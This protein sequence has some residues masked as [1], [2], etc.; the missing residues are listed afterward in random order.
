MRME[1]TFGTLSMEFLGNFSDYILNVCTIK[2]FLK[3]I[4]HWIQG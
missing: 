3:F 2:T 4:V 1:P